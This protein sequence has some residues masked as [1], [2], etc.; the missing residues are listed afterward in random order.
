MG[1]VRGRHEPLE[2]GCPSPAAG[3]PDLPPRGFRD[4]HMSP[5]PPSVHASTPSRGSGAAA[6]PAVAGARKD[7]NLQGPQNAITPRLE[8]GTPDG[9][10][11]AT[12]R[13]WQDTGAISA[14]R[15]TISRTTASPV[16]MPHSVLSTVSDHCT[17]AIQGGDDD[18]H[19][20]LL[21]H[22]APPCDYKRRRHASFKGGR[23]GHLLPWSPTLAIITLSAP[24]STHLNRLL[25]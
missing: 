7:P 24:L 4:L 1:G 9:D 16:A 2:E 3:V 12:C 6:C 20:P 17:P 8:D 25:F 15:R 19:A 22:A 21:M 10:D 13:G 11:H 5:G 23:S 18:F 14:G